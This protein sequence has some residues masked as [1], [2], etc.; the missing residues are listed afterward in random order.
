M[1]P[2]IPELPAPQLKTVKGPR[3]VALGYFLLVEIWFWIIYK[4]IPTQ[5]TSTFEVVSDEALSVASLVVY[6]FLWQGKNWARIGLMVLCVLLPALFLF[7]VGLHRFLLLIDEVAAND[8]ASTFSTAETV[9]F[10]TYSVFY[11][12]W[13]F[14]L[15]SPAMKAFCTKPPAPGGS[16]QRRRSLLQRE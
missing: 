5:E 3:P 9:Y 2:P 15:Q 4:F 7:G 8:F 16:V 6:W 11:L 14:W 13:F 1:N 10:S 12:V